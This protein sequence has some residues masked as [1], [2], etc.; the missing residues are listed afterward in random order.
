[1]WLRVCFALSAAACLYAADNQLTAE[2]KKAGWILLFDGH[3]FENWEDP[4]LKSPPGDSFTIDDGCL[5][6]TSHPKITEDLFTKQSWGDFDLAWDWKIA[7]RGNSGLKYRIQ[8]RVWVTGQTAPKFEDKVNAA[9]RNRLTTRPDHGQDYVIGFE[10]QMTD[11]TTN[12]DAVHNGPKH[13]TAA[14]YDIFAAQNTEPKPVG[15][16]NHSALVVRGKHVEH[17]LNGR[18]VLDARLDAPEIAAGMAKRWDVDSP[19]YSLLVSQPRVHCPISL[20]NH[21]DNAW[22]KNIKIRPLD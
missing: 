9:L 10:Y 6:A 11:D 4:T 20:Q 22:F 1:M 17:W 3:S 18:K 21:D 19:V 2:E 16:F 15:E 8:D 14:L 12:S 5:K 7:P 13:R